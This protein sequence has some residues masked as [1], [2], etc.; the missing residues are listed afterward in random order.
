[1]TALL[2]GWGVVATL[3]A[4]WFFLLSRST[5]LVAMRDREARDQARKRL[6][7]ERQG[8]IADARDAQ[9][10]LVQMQLEANADYAV[11]REERDALRKALH[12]RTAS[13]TETSDDQ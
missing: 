7:D 9:A 11:L 8:R 6:F 3:G 2:I 1:M 4:L 10:L 13:V 12:T 5:A